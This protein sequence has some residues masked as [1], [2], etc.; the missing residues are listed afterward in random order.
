MLTVV[1]SA[2]STI[3]PGSADL[4]T[5]VADLL[6]RALRNPSRVQWVTPTQRR[7]RWL[8]RHLPAV[9]FGR[10]LQCGAKYFHYRGVPRMFLHTFTQG[11]LTRELHRAGFQIEELIRLDANR[12]RPLRHHWLLGRIRANGWIAVCR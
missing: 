8:L 4:P 6:T 7:R 9:L 1:R 11:E 5:A 10:R 12:Q 3:D 2:Y